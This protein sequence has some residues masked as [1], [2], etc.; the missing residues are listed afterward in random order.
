MAARTTARELKAKPTLVLGLATGRSICNCS[1]WAATVASVATNRYPP[2]GPERARK[3][4]QPVAVMPTRWRQPDERHSRR[5]PIRRQ[6]PTLS[7]IVSRPP[8]HRVRLK[9]LDPED[10]DKHESKKTALPEIETLRQRMDQLQYQLYAEQKRSLL[11]CLQAPDAG[12]KD[13]V[14]RHVIASMNPQGC[15]A[16]SFKQPSAEELAHDFLWRIEGQTPRRGEVV[17]FNRSHYEDVLIVRV[18]DLVPRKVWSKRYEQINDFE[19]RLAAGGTQILKFF[20]HISKE[21]QLRRFKQR[22]DDPDR[23]W[24][25]SDGGLFGTRILG[26][27]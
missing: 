22:L 25:I 9:D 27:L 16:A 2:C 15:R 18:H 4:N 12:G 11:I 26:R 8:G 14:V 20:L 6:G 17:I 24:K 10:T 1:A 7:Q 13:G 23:Q 3:R 21:E 5:A 19:R